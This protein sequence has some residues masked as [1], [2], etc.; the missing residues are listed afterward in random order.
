MSTTISTTATTTVNESSTL[1]TITV[2]PRTD[3]R[4]VVFASDTVDNEH[5]NRK[6]SKIC[7]IYHKSHKDGDCSSS[8]TS[9][10]SDLSDSGPNAYER[11]PKHVRKLQSI[12]NIYF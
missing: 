4:R 12:I 9:S 3:S 1:G 11:Q 8:D 5:L 6:K 7:C 2:L 10:E